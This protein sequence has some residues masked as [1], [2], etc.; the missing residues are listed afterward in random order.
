MRCEFVRFGFRQMFAFRSPAMMS[1]YCCSTS[2]SPLKVGSPDV[3]W[4]DGDHLSSSAWKQS[5]W[6]HCG[7]AW[8]SPRCLPSRTTIR[9]WNWMRT[10]RRNED[11]LSVGPSSADL[12]ALPS[13]S[14]ALNARWTADDCTRRCSLRPTIHR[15]IGVCDG[16]EWRSDRKSR[17]L[18]SVRCS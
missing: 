16:P 6:S 15:T 2:W 3:C 18:S 11:R 1:D 4:T 10:T 12:M 8:Y 5:S 13:Y 9:N 17:S 7:F 14:P